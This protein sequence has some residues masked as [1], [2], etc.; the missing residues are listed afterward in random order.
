MPTVFVSNIGLSPC[1]FLPPPSNPKYPQ[2]CFQ[3]INRRDLLTSLA[4]SIT[5]FFTPHL[6]DSPSSMSVPLSQARG[7]F[8]M[9]PFR[10]SN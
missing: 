8:Q 2:N 1:P 7:L 6:T 5:P 10:I 9:P 3:P 4:L